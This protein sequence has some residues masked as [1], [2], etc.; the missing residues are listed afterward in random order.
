M[1]A[2][3]VCMALWTHWIAR[4]GCPKIITTDQGSPFESSLF[5]SLSNMVGSEHIHTTPYPPQPNGMVERWHRSLKAALMCSPETQWT[6]LLPTA[7]L[8]LRTCFKEDLQT[9]AAEMLYG[10]TLRL[11]NEYF[12]DIDT[13]SNPVEV[14]NNECSHVF[15]RTDSLK[16]PLEPPYSGPFQIVAKPSDRVFVVRINGK[17]TAL[18]IDRLKPAFVTKYDP[19]PAE[20]QSSQLISSKM[21]LIR[22]NSGPNFETLWFF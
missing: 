1:T 5:K 3:T 22:G 2:E 11:P 15:V 20:D 10:C 7:L 9:S 18:S 8:G 6:K 21:R 14:F 16:Q 12:F 17:D 19:N 13:P 4:F